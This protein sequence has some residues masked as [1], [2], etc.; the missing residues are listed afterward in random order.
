MKAISG[1]DYVLSAEEPKP[2]ADKTASVSVIIVQKPVPSILFIERAKRDEDKWSGQIALPGGRREVGD[3]TSLDT[4]IRE[5]REEIGVELHKEEFVGYMPAFKTNV[6]DL[7]VIPGVFLVDDKPTVVVNRNEVNSFKL[8]PL[9]YL[10]TDSAKQR[11][12]FS[13]GVKERIEDA[14]VYKDY[15]VWG[16]TYRII[17]CLLENHES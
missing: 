8:V 14:Y 11:Y 2:S 5:S 15:T 9:D 7:C 4:A 13:D 6:A 17:N 10:K 1:I 12:R 16:I 3:A